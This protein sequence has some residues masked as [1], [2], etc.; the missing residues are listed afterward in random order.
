MM[1]MASSNVISPRDTRRAREEPMSEAMAAATREVGAEIDRSRF[2]GL[3]LT[4]LVLC[5]LVAAFDGLDAQIIA[6]AAPALLPDLGLR[7]DQLGIIFSAATAGMAVGAVI[8]GPA[9]DRLGRKRVMVAMVA[10]FGLCT[11]ATVLATGFYDLLLIRFV[12]GIGMGGA[13]PNA[14]TL[15]SEYSPQRH[16]RL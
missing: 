1:A 5:F 16:R 7:D 11:L 14:V 4:V 10:L 13:L 8:F 15:V 9:G 12:T 6:F 3:Q 2:G